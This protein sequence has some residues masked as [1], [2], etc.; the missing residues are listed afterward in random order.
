MVQQ[1]QQKQSIRPGARGRTKG[2]RTDDKGAV[3]MFDEELE[4]QR[5]DHSHTDVEW[6]MEMISHADLREKKRAEERKMLEEK[7]DD[8]D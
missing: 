6:P 8:S 5:I 2:R 4:Q 3:S 7:G 1:Q